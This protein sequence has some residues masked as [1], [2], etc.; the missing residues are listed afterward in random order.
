VRIDQNV[1]LR[2]V[3]EECGD[4]TDS[5]HIGGQVV[6]LID[7]LGRFQAVFPEAQVELPEIVGSGL[8]ILRHFN[9]NAANPVTIGLQPL[10]EMMANESTGTSY[11]NSSLILHFVNSP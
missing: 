2:D 6:D 3:G 9:I 4:V 7:V 8:L 11:Q 10:D 5:A 1:V